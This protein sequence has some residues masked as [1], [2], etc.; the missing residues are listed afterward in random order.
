[1]NSARLR[2][3][4]IYLNP[5][6]YVRSYARSHYLLSK[7]QEAQLPTL[8]V[9]KAEETGLIGTNDSAITVTTISAAKASA[10]NRWGTGG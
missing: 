3:A 6:V 10:V 8:R 7:S 2:F 4:S 9:E 5:C 1:M